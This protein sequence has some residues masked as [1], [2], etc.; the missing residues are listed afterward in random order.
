MRL[1]P[2]HNKPHRKICDEISS[3]VFRLAAALDDADG[4]L[5]L[6]IRADINR[7]I[8]EAYHAALYGKE[9]KNADN[10]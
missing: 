9:T 1:S 4:P 8:A 5:A 2:H 10:R 3:K 6:S 7:L